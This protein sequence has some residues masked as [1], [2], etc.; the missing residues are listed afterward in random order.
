MILDL[1]S[2]GEGG[3]CPPFFVLPTSNFEFVEAYRDDSKDYTFI[4]E[5]LD[6][7]EAPLMD[8]SV[9]IWMYALLT[10]I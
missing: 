3:V 10:E 1:P 5:N 4:K 8:V 2:V 9:S 6:L 7:C